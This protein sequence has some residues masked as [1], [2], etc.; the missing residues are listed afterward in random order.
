MKNRSNIKTARG[1]FRYGC[2][3]RTWKNPSKLLVYIK[4]YDTPRPYARYTYT[5]V[6][7]LCFNR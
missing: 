5:H 7:R 2:K 1:K 4:I 3:R 6:D